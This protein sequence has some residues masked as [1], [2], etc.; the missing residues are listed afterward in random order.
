M[1][2]KAEGLEELIT[3]MDLEFK[4]LY[5]VAFWCEVRAFSL[6]FACNNCI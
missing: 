1:G 6:V 2:I 5:L 4:I 3:P